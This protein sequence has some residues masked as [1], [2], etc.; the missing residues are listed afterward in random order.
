MPIRPP[1][2]PPPL[3]LYDELNLSFHLTLIWRFWKKLF[4]EREELFHNKR[5]L[6]DTLKLGLL[7]LTDWIFQD[8]KSG[9]FLNIKLICKKTGPNLK[10]E[11]AVELTTDIRVCFPGLLGL[12][13]RAQT[14]QAQTWPPDF[15]DTLRASPKPALH[16]GPS[17]PCFP[18][19]LT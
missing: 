9:T 4:K 11:K 8:N 16:R 6:L 7:K 12:C 13:L 14:Q 3:S 2:G 17:G 19:H 1:W 15:G 5:I 18:S 10:T